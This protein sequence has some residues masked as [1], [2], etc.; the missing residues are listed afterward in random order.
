MRGGNIEKMVY[1]ECTLRAHNIKLLCLT[2]LLVFALFGCK[3]ASRDDMHSSQV[4]ADQLV[5]CGNPT[6]SERFD[7]YWLD[8]SNGKLVNLTEKYVYNIDDAFGH[9]IGCDD[10]MRPYRTTGAAWS[11]NGKLLIVNAGGPYL[12]VPYILEIS[13]TGEILK[14]VQ[15]WP[16]PRPGKNIYD[17]PMDFAWSPN[18]DEVGFDAMTDWDGYTNLFIGDVSEWEHSNPDT[19]VKQLTQEYRYFP[20]IVYAPS[21]SPDGEKIAVS[22]AGPTSGIIIVPIDGSQLVH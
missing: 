8:L 19:P 5:F 2:F 15:Q 17:Y 10:D 1:C 6:G 14:I 21:W 18:G 7:I 13:D 3:L 9:S 12:L 22:L 20:G 11:P 4:I 16:A